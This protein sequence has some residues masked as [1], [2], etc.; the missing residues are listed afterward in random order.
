VRSWS[1]CLPGLRRVPLAQ[2]RRPSTWS[3]TWWA[4]SSSAVDTAH[5]TQSGLQVAR[6]EKDP[7]G[8]TEFVDW[9]STVCCICCRIGMEA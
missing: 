8:H 9:L 2:M 4:C 7:D 6:H 5:T 3:T 1:G